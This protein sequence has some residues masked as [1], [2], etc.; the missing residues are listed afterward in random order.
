MSILNG[1]VQKEGDASSDMS[2]PKSSTSIPNAYSNEKERGKA[3]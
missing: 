1:D 3:T 2:S